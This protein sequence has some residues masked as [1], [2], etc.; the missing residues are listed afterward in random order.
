[1]SLLGFPPTLWLAA[2]EHHDALLREFVLYTAEHG[3]DG[4][5]A[6]VPLADDARAWLAAAVDTGMQ[7]ARDAGVS[8]AC[9]RPDTRARC[10]RLLP[11][12]T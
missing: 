9:S 1:V 7:R 6:A 5:A 3:E 12:S 10:P 8:P 4:D 2:A 11:P